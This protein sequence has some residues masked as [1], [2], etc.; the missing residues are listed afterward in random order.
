MNACLSTIFVLLWPAEH[1]PVPERSAP[2]YRWLFPRIA[3]L[4]V[5]AAGLLVAAAT[6]ATL[7]MFGP[8][9]APGAG[10]TPDIRFGPNASFQR[11]QPTARH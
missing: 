9:P 3:V 6:D 1:E 5:L 10:S 4:G 7:A 11:E 8:N 2:N